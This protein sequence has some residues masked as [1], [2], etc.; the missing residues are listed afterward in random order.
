MDDGFSVERLDAFGN[1]NFVSGNLLDNDT[2]GTDGRAA[3]PIVRLIDE[4]G[5]EYGLGLAGDA[6]AEAIVEA[7]YAQGHPI[8]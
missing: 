6:A 3:L 8:L 1:P 7:M 4:A 5:F 2:F